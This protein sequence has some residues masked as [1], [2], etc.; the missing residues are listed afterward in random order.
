MPCPPVAS[1]L[2]MRCPPSASVTASRAAWP[3]WRRPRGPRRGPPPPRPPP[4]GAGGAGGASGGRRARGG[5]VLGGRRRARGTA[6]DE[7]ADA[8]APLHQA[9]VL[10][11]PVGLHHGVGVDGH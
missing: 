10:K 5:P 4:G 8:L 3:R 9:L 7:R 1:G 2:F 11:L 6:R